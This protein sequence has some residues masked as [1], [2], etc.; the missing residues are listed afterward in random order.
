[1]SGNQSLPLHSLQ[2]GKPITISVVFIQQTGRKELSME[3]QP[4]SLRRRLHYGVR[5][6]VKNA[7][8]SQFIH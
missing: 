8:V 3:F 7:N 2:N 1:M 5:S 6:A 4:G